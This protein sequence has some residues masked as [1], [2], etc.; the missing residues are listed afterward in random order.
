MGIFSPARQNNT[1]T[2]RVKPNDKPT[3]NEVIKKNGIVCIKCLKQILRP[4]KANLSHS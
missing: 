2:E 1:H 3:E 4:P